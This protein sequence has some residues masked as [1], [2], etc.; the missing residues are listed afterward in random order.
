ME[1]DIK[2]V[3]VD[4]DDKGQDPEASIPLLDNQQNNSDES[5]KA[6]DDTIGK[7]I[8]GLKLKSI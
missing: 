3:K 8:C 1:K 2:N 6:E 4:Q 7:E 5:K